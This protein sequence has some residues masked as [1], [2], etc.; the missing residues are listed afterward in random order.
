MLHQ[1]SRALARKALFCCEP[2]A[3]YEDELMVW[4]EESHAQRSIANI[5]LELTPT[6]LR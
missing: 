3:A 5:K 2:R 6:V 1:Q 4:Y